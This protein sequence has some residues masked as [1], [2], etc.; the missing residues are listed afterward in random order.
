MPLG[1]L[2][3]CRFRDHIPQ[4]KGGGGGIQEQQSFANLNLFDS[5][6]I[7]I[8]IYFHSICICYIINKNISNI[9]IVM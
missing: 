8:G 6:T 9:Y 1:E 7:L 2:I 3:I 5:N 4:I